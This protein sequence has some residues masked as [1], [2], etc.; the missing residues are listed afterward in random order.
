M[1]LFADGDIEF[2][3]SPYD[4]SETTNTKEEEVT[5]RIKRQDVKCAIPMSIRKTDRMCILYLKLAE[6]LA[7]DV[8]SFTLEFDG[9]VIQK[10]D[11]IESLDLEGDE[12][13]D[14]FPKKK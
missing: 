4:T 1:F 12:C 6:K 14:L 2:Y 7:L 5:F 9:D 11:T 8:E 10:S 3:K 13:F